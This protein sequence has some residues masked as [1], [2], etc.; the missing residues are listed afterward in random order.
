MRFVL[1]IFEELIKKTSMHSRDAMYR[2]FIPPLE[3]YPGELT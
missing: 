1:F 3:I 2:L